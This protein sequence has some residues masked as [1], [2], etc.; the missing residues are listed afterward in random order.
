MDGLQLK[1]LIETDPYMSKM[2]RGILNVKEIEKI[3]TQ[4]HS[5]ARAYIVYANHHW[6]LLV[7]YPSWTILY[8]DPLGEKPAT[9]SAH[10]ANWLKSLRWRVGNNLVQIQPKGSDKCGLYILYFMYYL[11]RGYK[12]E[13]I[14]QKFHRTNLSLNDKLVSSFV[15]KKFNFEIK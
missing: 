4:R 13:K 5:Y 14:M 3:S 10:F 11:S 15:F 1:K 6:L 2:L 9:Y 7:F 8:M 12:F